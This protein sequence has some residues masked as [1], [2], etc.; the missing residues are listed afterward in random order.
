MPRRG[1]TLSNL[2]CPPIRT[3]ED[4]RERLSRPSSAL[5]QL[6]KQLKGD[7]LI[8]GVSGKVGPE[9]AR[10][11]VRAVA[12]SQKPRRIMGVA[13]FSD[14]RQRT[15]L[16]KL[17]VE[18]VK[19]NLHEDGAFDR[20]PDAENVL[21]LVGRKF[22]STGAEWQTW[23]TNVT[24]AGLAAKRYAKS[25]VVAF[26]TGNVYPFVSVGSGGASESTPLGPVGEYAMSCLGRERMFDNASNEFGARVL[27]F[28]LNYAVELRYGILHDV[29]IRVWTKQ[30]VNLASGHVNVVWQG[31]VNEVALRS[32]DMA[33][34]PPAVLN[35]T[36]PET[37]SIR[38]LAERFGEIF[39]KKPV[40]EGQESDSAL[41]SNAS[42]CFGHFGYPSVTLDVLVGWTAH[43]VASGGRA[44][45]K[46][47]HYDT[48]DGRF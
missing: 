38:W 47:T 1:R 16:E 40:F 19:A 17:G 28:R 20:L 14:P 2:T 8:L 25:S 21:F 27:H 9:L 42:R 36:G 37:V 3:E 34:S 23:T 33:A 39:R 22:G 18:T 30:P 32:L 12:E 24:L 46:P 4:L 5:I 7:I 10:M 26:S 29:A 15:Y 11:A 13:S 43:W 45:G 44:L 41:L 6:I 35:V 31:Y 48:R